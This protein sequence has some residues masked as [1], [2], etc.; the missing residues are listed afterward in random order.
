MFYT[1]GILSVLMIQADGHH[2]SVELR[3]HFDVASSHTV[4]IYVDSMVAFKNR[5]SG[6]GIVLIAPFVS[7]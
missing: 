4:K 3:M 6:S 7:F 2:W 5:I 1:K